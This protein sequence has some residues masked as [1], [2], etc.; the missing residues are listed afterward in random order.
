MTKGEVDAWL[1]RYIVAWQSYEHAEIAALFTDDVE[2][3]YHP[4]DEPVIGADTIARS[5]V[6]AERRDEPG[7]WDAEYSCVAVDGDV[8][9]AT[10][11][12]NYY[13]EP[14]GGYTNPL[15]QLFR[16]AIRRG[17]QVQPIHRVLHGAPEGPLS[18]SRTTLGRSI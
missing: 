1:R 6:E 17:W 18:I 8:A 7:T 2:Y 3:R 12:S 5:W 14:G 11:Q 15:L 9:V 4:W 10:G 13:V 16:D